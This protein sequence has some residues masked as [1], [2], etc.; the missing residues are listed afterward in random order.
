MVLMDPAG[1]LQLHVYS[2][3]YFCTNNSTEY[4][5]LLLGLTLSAKLKVK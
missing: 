5:V 1:Q 4:E 2:L 3:S